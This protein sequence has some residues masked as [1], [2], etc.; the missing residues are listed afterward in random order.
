MDPQSLHVFVAAA[1]AGTILGAAT[2]CNTSRGRVRRKLEEFEA[3]AGT[4]LFVRERHGLTLTQAGTLLL[5]RVEPIVAELEVLRA[6]AH[7]AGEAPSGVLKI[8]ANALT[9]SLG[10][11]EFF[12]LCE[13]MMPDVRVEGVVTSDVPRELRDGCE[14]GLLLAESVPEGP[15]TSVRGVTFE[16][17]LFASQSYVE[18]HG[19][20]TSPAEL[21]S[22]RIAGWSYPGADGRSIPLRG[23]GR[24]DVEPLFVSSYGEP[25]FQ[26]VLAGGAIGNL[27]ASA[28]GDHDLIRVLPDQVGYDV[29]VFVLLSRAAMAIPRVREL[30]RL[31]G[32]VANQ[33]P[34]T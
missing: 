1:R 3:W 6:N 2:A 26:L 9:P 19:L 16:A 11:A 13:Q 25:V 22:H 24:I 33:L 27:S 30:H 14:V 7:R 5:E 10:V 32:V 15:W 29:H 12:T 23:G 8:A 20:P 4:A 28:F 31:I 18:R 34:P 21:T 17:G